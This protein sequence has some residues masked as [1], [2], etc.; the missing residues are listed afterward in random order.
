MWFLKFLRSNVFYILW[1][2]L[3]FGF[4]WIIFGGNL[5]SFIIV[6]IIYGISMTIALC[7]IGEV[8]LRFFEDCRLPATEQE[9]AYLTPLFEEVYRQAK[10]VNPNLNNGIKLYIM[11]AMYV[12]AFAIGRKTVAVT[13]GAMETFTRDE[14]KGVLAHELGHMI[15]GHTKALLLTVIGNI[16]FS[17]IVWVLRLLLYILELASVILAAFNFIGWIFKFMTMVTRI[18]FNIFVFVFINAGQLILAFNSQMNEFQADKFAFDTGYGK[19]QIS[20]LYLLQKISMNAKVKWSEKLKASHPHTA[21]RI[22]YLE[23]LEKEESAE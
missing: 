14:L 18:V 8:L 9:K 19:E 4:A 15:Y 10:E 11:D 13:R 22:Q 1:F 5:N 7:P 16:L 17:I 3:Y 23:G 12:N 21:N 2:L 6:S 20:A